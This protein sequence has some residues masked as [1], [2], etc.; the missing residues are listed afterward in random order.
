MAVK[1]YTTW[2][3]WCQRTK[4]FLKSKNIKFEEVNVEKDHK[5]AHE[6]I[7]KSGQSGVRPF[8]LRNE[9]RAMLRIMP[10]MLSALSEKKHK[11]VMEKRL[12]VLASYSNEQR[13]EHMKQ[14]IEGLNS[15]PENDRISL[16]KNMMEVI[17]GLPERKRKALMFTMDKL[18]FGRFKLL[19]N[20][21]ISRNKNEWNKNLHN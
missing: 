19:P 15:L 8:A 21:L 7:E 16:R 1:I 5:A 4:Q 20:K 14:M 3:P 13:L 9:F 11:E 6:M 17:A 2:C 18:M 12:T 10:W